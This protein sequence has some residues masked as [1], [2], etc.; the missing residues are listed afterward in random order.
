MQSLPLNVMEGI[1]VIAFLPI[2]P[3]SPTRFL[4][5]P[6]LLFAWSVELDLQIAWRTCGESMPLDY[7][8]C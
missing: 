1:K 8:S 3:F 2:Q 7:F 4:N 5:Y 6:R